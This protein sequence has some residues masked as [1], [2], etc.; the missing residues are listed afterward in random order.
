MVRNRFN[1]ICLIEFPHAFSD[2]EAGSRAPSKETNAVETDTLLAH[3][4]LSCGRSIH[5][6]LS[7]HTHYA[8]VVR[9]GEF[10]KEVHQ[11]PWHDLMYP[12]WCIG[13]TML[14][15]HK[16]LTSQRCK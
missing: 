13:S 10:S 9:F 16:F 2:R 1:S 14:C 7:S 8:A 6:S 15:I 4:I 11:F 12:C 5:L 3:E